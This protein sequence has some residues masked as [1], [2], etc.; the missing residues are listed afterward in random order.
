MFGPLHSTEYLAE[1]GQRDV[2]LVN[3][4]RLAEALDIDIRD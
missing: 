2:G 4:E 3:P 1:R